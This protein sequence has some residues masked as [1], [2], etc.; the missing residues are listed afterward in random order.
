[1]PPD[2]F[3]TGAVYAVISFL[4]V[5]APKAQF[6]IFGVIP[7]PAWAF[8]TGIFFYD[9]YQSLQ[10]FVRAPIASPVY[11]RNADMF[12]SDPKQTPLD[13]SEVYWP[14]LASILVRG[15]GYSKDAQHG[16]HSHGSGNLSLDMG[17][18][19]PL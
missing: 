12:R 2:P 13:T 17:S 5:I 7:V 16:Y 9:S 18:P 4:A 11:S 14:A 8:V 19:L 15:S 3:S 1:M 10:D 6:A